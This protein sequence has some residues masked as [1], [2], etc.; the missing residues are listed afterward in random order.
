MKELLKLGKNSFALFETLL[1]ILILS[2]IIV[3]FSNIAYYDNF[4]KEFT[5]LN[6]LDNSFTKN[7][8][9]KNFNKSS[10]KL[11][12]IENETLKKQKIVNQITFHNDLI[13]IKK[14]EL[15]SE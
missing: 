11:I 15:K 12:I 2:I 13:F 1:S 7:N 9:D 14:Y 8:F 10:K 3:S 6:K 5:L 4:D